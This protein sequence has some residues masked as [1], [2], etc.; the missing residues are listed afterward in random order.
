[1]QRGTLPRLKEYE[2]EQMAD[3]KL[4]NFIVKSV[5]ASMALEADYPGTSELSEKLMH[6]VARGEITAD[7]AASILKDHYEAKEND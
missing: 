7:E 1:M 3:K 2:G 6:K 5:K 4:E